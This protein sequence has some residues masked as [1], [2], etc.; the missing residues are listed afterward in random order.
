[1][2]DITYETLSKHVTEDLNARISKF[3]K[4]VADIGQNF[5]N[6]GLETAVWY[7]ER[8]HST[9][10]GG[11]IADSYIGYSRIEG[12]W[13][14][15]IRTIERDHESGA[16]ISQRVFSLESCGNMEIVVNALRKARELVSYIK[17]TTER[18][19]EILGNLNGEIEALRSPECKF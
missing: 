6:L 14:L 9:N 19:I 18:Q 4:A 7:P 2:G 15:L 11:I 10:L 12:R 16:F 5:R 13:G 3:K 1:M 8:I 17:K